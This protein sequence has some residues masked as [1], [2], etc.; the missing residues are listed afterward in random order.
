MLNM[1]KCASDQTK[2]YSILYAYPI[3]CPHAYTVGPC[4]ICL[5]LSVIIVAVFNTLSTECTDGHQSDQLAS[6]TGTSCTGACDSNIVLF[7][8]HCM[9]YTVV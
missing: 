6:T 7:L 9:T 2:A 8:F 3:I 4:R 5:G 1:P